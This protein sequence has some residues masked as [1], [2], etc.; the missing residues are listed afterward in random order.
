MTK[1]EIPEGRVEDLS[2]PAPWA[3]PAAV[4]ALVLVALLAALVR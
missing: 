2:D 4:L 3:I 1:R